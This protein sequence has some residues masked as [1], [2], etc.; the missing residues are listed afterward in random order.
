[1]ILETKKITKKYNFITIFKNLDLTIEQNKSYLILGKNGSGKSTLLKCLMGLIPIN[2]GT[3][4]YSTNLNGLIKLEK[5]GCVAPYLDVFTDLTAF[6]N[7]EL[8][9]R[10]HGLQ[11]T[12]NDLIKKMDEFQLEKKIDVTTH[13]YSSGMMQRFKLLCATLHNPLLLALDEAASMLDE[14]GKNLLKN[15]IE[16]QKKNGSVLICTNESEQLTWGE[17]LF[18]FN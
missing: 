14:E 4:N 9:N 6:E 3:I 16:L 17:K 15:V 10:F 1:M 2:S 5:M 11:L 12:K 8:L 18:E 13:H 7:L